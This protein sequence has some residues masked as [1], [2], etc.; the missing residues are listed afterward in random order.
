MNDETVRQQT[1]DRD[2]VRGRWGSA[3]IERRGFSSFVIAWMTTPTRRER[4]IIGFGRSEA[5]AWADARKYVEE[6]D[7]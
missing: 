7:G 6:H 4:K 3:T 1:T 5:A 2:F